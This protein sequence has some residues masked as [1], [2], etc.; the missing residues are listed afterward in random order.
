MDRLKLKRSALRTQV[1][2]L[3]SEAELFLASDANDGA[4]S[5]LSSRLSALQLQLNE[6]DNAIEPL[7][8]DE[9][10]EQNYISTIEYN[11]RIVACIAKLS[12]EAEEQK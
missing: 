1:T 10:A 2:K 7:V 3:I 12:Q 6:V 8:V 11:D 5:V 9:D 4:L